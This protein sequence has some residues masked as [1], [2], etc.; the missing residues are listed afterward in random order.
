VSDNMGKTDRIQGLG[1]LLAL[2]KSR[3]QNGTKASRQQSRSHSTKSNKSRHSIL[4]EDYNRIT[5]LK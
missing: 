1:K 3:R 4:I 2:K 5:L